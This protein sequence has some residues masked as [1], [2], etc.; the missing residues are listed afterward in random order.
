MDDFPSKQETILKVAVSTLHSLRMHM[1][2]F[3]SKCVLVIEF[4]E[5]EHYSVPVLNVW[6]V[7][8]FPQ[9]SLE[10][11]LLGTFASYSNKN[12][13]FNFTMSVCWHVTPQNSRTDFYEI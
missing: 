6:Y 4:K 1:F 8:G 9:V 10:M 7:I 12:T 2:F 5:M 13:R 11:Q 3:S